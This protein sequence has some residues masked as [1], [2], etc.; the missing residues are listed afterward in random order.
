MIQEKD[1]H[2]AQWWNINKVHHSGCLMDL[3]RKIPYCTTFPQYIP[4]WL[5]ALWKIVDK[6]IALALTSSQNDQLKIVVGLISPKPQLHFFLKQ[7]EAWALS[8]RD[9]IVFQKAQPLEDRTFWETYVILKDGSQSPLWVALVTGEP[10]PLIYI[11]QWW[12]CKSVPRFINETSI[13]K[14]FKVGIIQKNYTCLKYYSGGRN[15][16]SCPRPSRFY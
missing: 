3:L 1:W 15:K 16:S 10:G 4:H 5:N 2:W 6:L 13:F 7:C 12:R 9:G 11:C 14:I 8:P